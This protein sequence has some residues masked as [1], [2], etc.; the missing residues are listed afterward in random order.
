[1][2]K[3]FIYYLYNKIIGVSYFPWNDSIIKVY[4]RIY[5]LMVSGSEW[6]QY[7]WIYGSFLTNKQQ[8]NVKL[9]HFDV[10]LYFL[11]ENLCT[12]KHSEF[13]SFVLKIVFPLT[14]I[15]AL[16]KNSQAYSFFDASHTEAKGKF[17]HSPKPFA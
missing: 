3:T 17:N 8:L 1:M 6:T 7:L 9:T 10:Q 14:K 13:S 11:I 16:F 4:P 12:G 2:L 15:S 5:C